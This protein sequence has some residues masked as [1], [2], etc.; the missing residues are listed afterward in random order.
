MVRLPAPADAFPAFDTP[1]GRVI[2]SAGRRRA[3]YP[4]GTGAFACL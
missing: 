4:V 2:S 3:M 1:S